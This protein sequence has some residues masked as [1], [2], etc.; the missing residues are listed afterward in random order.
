MRPAPVWSMS[1]VDVHSVLGSG[2]RSLHEMSLADARSSPVSQVVWSTG[3][4]RFHDIISEISTPMR[5]FCAL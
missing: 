5:T 4:E 3:V 1:M 2:E